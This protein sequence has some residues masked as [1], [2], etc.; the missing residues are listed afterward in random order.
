MNDFILENNFM[1]TSDTVLDCNIIQCFFGTN[2]EDIHNTKKSLNYIYNSLNVR[3]KK[4]IFIEA[5]K[6]I[7]DK[8]FEY[9]KDTFNVDYIFKQYDNES[10][11]LYLKENLWNIS[12]DYTD[13]ENL[14][15]LDE[16]IF[17]GKSDW[18][19]KL[20]DCFDK[21]DIFHPFDK[22]YCFDTKTTL[23][24]FLKNVDSNIW[25]VELYDKSEF[26]CGVCIKKSKLININ[27]FP[28]CGTCNAS[29]LFWNNLISNQSKYLD[30]KKY[31]YNLTKYEV[32][33][34]IQH[35]KGI[36]VKIGYCD[37]LLVYKKLNKYE[38]ESDNRN[39]LSRACNS[40][41]FSDIDDSNGI[42]KW[43]ND[44]SAQIHKTVL[45]KCNNN[46]DDNFIKILDDTRLEKYGKASNPVIATVFRK[47]VNFNKNIVYLVNTLY[48]EY[49][50]NDFEFCVI[51][52]DDI[53]GIKTIPFEI[54]DRN[55]SPGCFFQNELF[56]NVF[57]DN[58]VILSVDL[59]VI[60]LRH[61]T[62]PDIP[63]NNIYMP[64]E[65]NDMYYGA[66]G[67]VLWNGGTSLYKGDFSFIFN[68]YK[69]QIEKYGSARFP[70]YSFISSQEYISGC[71]FKYNIIPK[72][73]KT[74]LNYELYISTGKTSVMKTTDIV[75]LIGDIKEWNLKEKPDWM[76]DPC[77]NI[78]KNFKI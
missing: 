55:L 73:I 7:N 76:P 27:K 20:Y 31:P 24:P 78:I 8:K 28:L 46:V 54:K 6:S 45:Q 44:I 17:F 36:D 21:Y 68:E 52:D 41:E 65:F 75:H 42:V 53:P 35:I 19:Q 29:T 13:S 3:P 10:D 37:D 25:N 11:Y 5:Q 2:E 71:L 4:W 74:V 70:S 1:N 30:K 60:P 69:S 32:L 62:I 56:R 26:R 15:F 38:K 49:C 9:L 61:F 57:G 33:F 34:T 47:G 63:V 72:D 14:I 48:K 67:R 66:A 77:W 18:L 40:Y 51:T 39:L 64:S 59:D 23:C 12:L 50:L 43:S 22:C 16:N 58:R